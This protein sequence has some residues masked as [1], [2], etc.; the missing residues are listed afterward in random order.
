MKTLLF[1]TTLLFASSTIVAQDFKDFLKLFEKAEL[2]YTTPDACYS[3]FPNEE[4]EFASQGKTIE[5]SF[6]SAFLEAPE[7]GYDQFEAVAKIEKEKYVLLIT[8]ETQISMND[9]SMRM[10][11]KMYSFSKSGEYIDSRILAETDN[12]YGDDYWETNDL[13]AT[14]GNGTANGDEKKI[15]ITYRVVSTKKKS[16]ADYPM[17]TVSTTTFYHLTDEAGNIKE[18]TQ[19]WE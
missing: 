17:K 1:A 15:L 9:G 12:W 11:F 4:Q 13:I 2:P 5:T 18:A 19:N 3:G 10:I 14:I 6:A 7:D 8:Y 16:D